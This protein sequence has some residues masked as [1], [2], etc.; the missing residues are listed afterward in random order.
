MIA[1][2]TAVIQAAR[3]PFNRANGIANWP[4][5]S[6]SC[7][8]WNGIVRRRAAV[9]ARPARNPPVGHRQQRRR[10]GAKPQQPRSAQNRRDLRRRTGF[11]HRL[12]KLALP[13]EPIEKDQHRAGAQGSP[14]DDLD[15]IELGTL[16][17][18]GAAGPRL[19][20]VV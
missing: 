3:D 14:A 5:W 15:E 7:G 19:L 4:S 9:R 16:E 8:K 20:R 6:S 12:R 17:A 10:L 2:K 11:G 13:A 18:A 1:T